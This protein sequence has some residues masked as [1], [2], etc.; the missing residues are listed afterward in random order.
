ML[1]RRSDTIRSKGF[2]DR[3]LMGILGQFVLPYWAPMIL[4]FLLLLVVMAMTALLPYLIQLAVDGPITEGNLSA[5]YGY[6]IAYFLAIVLLFGARFAHTYL[7]QTVGQAV[8]ERIRQT[9]YEHLLNMEMAHFNRTPLGQMVSRMTNDIEAL[10]ELISTSI[11]MVVSNLITLIGLV[12]TMLLINWRMALLAFCVLPV[13]AL[14]SLYF[15]KKIRT[16]S[17]RFHKIIADYQAFLNEQFNGMLV[18]QLFGREAQSRAEFDVVNRDYRDVHLSLRD[19]FTRYSSS[20][21][22]LTTVGLA[23]LL[24]GGGRGV[25]AQW[26]TLGMLIAFMQYARQSYEPILQL[27][28]QFAQIQQALSAGERIA[29]TLSMSPQI[30]SPKLAV[31][32]NNFRQ[33]IHCQGLSFRYHKNIPVLQSIDLR[34]EKGEHVAIVGSTGAGKT[35]LASL[36]V[37]L[38]DVSEGA[39]FLDGVDLRKISLSQLPQLVCQVP[40]NPYI[41]DGTI[42]DNLRLFDDDISDERLRRAAEI[43]C[44]APII[45]QLSGGYEHRLLPGGGNLSEGQRQLLAL[46]RAF[47]HSPNSILILDEATSNIDT[48]TEAH[49]QRGLLQVMRGRTRITIAHRL[50]TVRDADR[51]LYMQQGKI[52]EDG[53]HE[54]L[55][56][57]GGSYYQLIHHQFADREET[58]SH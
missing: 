49:I 36:L 47:I 3:N 40:Q 35:T 51:I 30:A 33:N 8:L 39:I 20:L 55:M 56:A 5:I 12:V 43:A 11:V 29:E 45:E 17:A 52:I 18:I 15:R 46:T 25:L 9:L 54:E 58:D 13:M 48:E 57:L 44:A 38:Y 50:S 22:L 7:L 6:A 34:I 24:Y 37:R 2:S 27:A 19:S 28:E 14:L 4:V 53:S 31:N 23:L 21:Q 10:T 16:A 41:F 26:A 32:L 42:A 1:S